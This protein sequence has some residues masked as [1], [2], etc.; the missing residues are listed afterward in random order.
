MRR[1]AIRCAIL[2]LIVVLA[3][4]SREPEAASTAPGATTPAV[5]TPAAPPTE[6]V[7]AVALG[8]DLPALT[9]RFELSG[10]PVVGQPVKIA[11]ELAAQEALQAVRLQGSSTALTLTPAEMTIADLAAGAPVRHEF[12]I[13]PA[14]AGLAELVLQVTAQTAAGE[15][16]GSFSVPLLVSAAAGG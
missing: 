13:T 10:K 8:T 5:A 4:C 7:A 12:E 14:A 15:R 16:K 11:V 3:G 1:P 6:S 9:V 2:A